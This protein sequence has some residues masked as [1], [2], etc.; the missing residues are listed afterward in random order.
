MDWFAAVDIYCER[1]NA[2]F[3]AEP[4]NAL[5]NLAVLVPVLWAAARARRQRETDPAIW[6]LIALAAAIGLGSFLFHTVATRWAEVADTVP[7]WGFLALYAYAAA[8]RLLGLRP[9]R[10][11]ALAL[12]L[13]AVLVLVFVANGEGAALAA[14][15]ERRPAGL[16]GSGQYL[17]AIAVAVVLS[18]AVW[19]GRHPLRGWVAAAC[20]SFAA[21]ITLRTLDAGLCSS[22][23]LGTHFLWHIFNVLTLGLALRVLLHRPGAASAPP[24]GRVRRALPAPRQEAQSR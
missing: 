8:D 11:Q 4:V 13:V 10:P 21:A 22:L 19:R 9:E 14:D 17:P 23:P 6:A 16:N 20:L 12:V 5:T 24:A 3:W 7:I 2:S 18:A 1:T 15:T